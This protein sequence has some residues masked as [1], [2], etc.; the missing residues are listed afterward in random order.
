MQQHVLGKQRLPV[1]GNRYLRSSIILFVGFIAL[2]SALMFSVSLGATNIKIE[3][4]WQALFHNH[5]PS[6]ET[7]IV[8]DIRLPRAIAGAI[9]GAAF[10]VAGAMMQGVTRNPLADPSLLGVNAGA[11]LAISICFA[12][13]PGLSYSYLIVISFIGAAVGAGM[14]YGLGA[15][16]RGGNSPVKLILAGAAVGALLVAIHEGIAIYYRLSQDL[17]FW[18]AGGISGVK[19]LQIELMLPWVGVGLIGAVVL[20]RSITIMSLG[21]DVA[22]GLGQR[23]IITKLASVLIILLLAGSAVSAVGAIGFVGLIVPHVVRYMVGQQYQ[24]IIPGCILFGGTLVVIADIGA[25]M[26]NAPYETPVG[27]MISALGVPFFLYLSR[28]SKGRTA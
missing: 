19:W 20:S 10:A 27:A 24:W 1:S 28:K 14:V 15:L 6:K 17:L 3:T 23:L 12:F 25:R 5:S 9:V 13:Y 21:D 16:S 18:Y 8:M 22:I 4:I 2:L 11:A 26:F 7:Q